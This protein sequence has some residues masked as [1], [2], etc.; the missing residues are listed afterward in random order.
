MLFMF[1]DLIF[2]ILIKKFIV[3]FFLKKNIFIKILSDFEEFC[4]LYRI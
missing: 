3:I 2:K 4:I 1:K